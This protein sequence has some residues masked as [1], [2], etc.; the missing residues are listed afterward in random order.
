MRTER[1]QKQKAGSLRKISK[2]D[3]P[4]ARLTGKKREDINNQYQKHKDL[5]EYLNNFYANKSNK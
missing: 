1:K 4:L 3:K 5:Q 2:T